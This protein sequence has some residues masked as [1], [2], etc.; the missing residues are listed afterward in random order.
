VVV[1]VSV[2]RVVPVGPTFL[3]RVVSVLGPD[4]SMMT[5]GFDFST[6]IGVLGFSTMTV[7]PPEFGVVF[8][9]I[10]PPPQPDIATQKPRLKK[11]QARVRIRKFLPIHAVHGSEKLAP[12]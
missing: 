2:V 6:I 4:L 10:V 3:V 8:T 5:V 9:S 12:V 11:Q 1:F 7:G